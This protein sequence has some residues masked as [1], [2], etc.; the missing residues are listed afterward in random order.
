MLFRSEGLWTGKKSGEWNDPGNWCREKIPTPDISVL[1]PGGTVFNPELN[2]AGFCDTLEIL[3]GGKMLLKG[4]LQVRGN[5][6]AP[7]SS[8]HATNG[9]VVFNGSKAQTILGSQFTN[10]TI[11]A[12]QVQNN[13]GLSI[14]DSITVN[15]SIS[16]Q[17]GF[18]QTN[19]LLIIKEGAVVGPSAEGS[20]ILGNVQ[21]SKTVVSAKRQYIRHIQ[22]KKNWLPE[23]SPTLSIKINNIAI[24]TYLILKMPFMKLF[25]QW[26]RCRFCLPQ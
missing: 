17:K 5:I 1:I 2:T 13:M 21:V 7:S 26:S 18:I 4:L 24:M 22:T 23:L 14:Q 10:H 12:L 11:G 20:R 8:I 25:W 3:A 9:S 6:L 15:Q 19:N 16:I